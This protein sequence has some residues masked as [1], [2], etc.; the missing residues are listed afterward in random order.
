MS[1]GAK[2]S[3]LRV[4]QCHIRQREIDARQQPNRTRQAIAK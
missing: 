2:R 1:N 4:P 3:P